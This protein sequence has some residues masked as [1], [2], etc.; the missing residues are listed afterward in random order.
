MVHTN[1]FPDADMLPLGHIG[2]RAERGD[3][4]KS[5]LT[6]DE[7]YTLMSLWSIFRSPLMMGGDLPTS[8]SFTYELLTNNEVLNVDQH[9][10]NGHEAYRDTNIIVWTADDLKSGAKYVGVF[11]V[12]DAIQKIELPWAK[13]GL[14]WEDPAVRDLW[15]HE[16][17]GRMTS[18]K[19]S[20]RPHASVLCK[21][22]KGGD[23]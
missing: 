6:Q 1:S 22:S 19:L 17:N 18:L 8:D 7:Q 3:N 12:G 13:I 5:L 10:D 23:G 14:P 20:L 2:I 15:R 9:S 16:D 11:N 21:V 4:R